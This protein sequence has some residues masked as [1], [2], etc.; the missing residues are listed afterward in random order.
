MQIA[1]GIDCQRLFFI[2]EHKAYVGLAAGE[3]LAE[4]AALIGLQPD[5]LDVVDIYHGVIHRADID[6]DSAIFK[7]DNG[8][9]L[10]DAGLHRVGKDGFK[11]FGQRLGAVDA[12]NELTL[13][14]G[15]E[16]IFPV[17]V[18]S[19]FCFMV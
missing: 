12:V 4:L 2:L 14:I 10:F 15:K 11:G 3:K 17:F 1:V 7:G 16:L 19:W 6:G 13:G 9:V 8:D 5:P 18:S